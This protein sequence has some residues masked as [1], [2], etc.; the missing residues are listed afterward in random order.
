VIFALIALWMLAKMGQEGSTARGGD[1]RE[2]FDSLRDSIKSKLGR[3]RGKI[4]T[5]AQRAAA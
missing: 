4:A 1:M 3:G 5:D 2:M